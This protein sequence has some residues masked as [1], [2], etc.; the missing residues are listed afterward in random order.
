MIVQCLYCNKEFEKSLCDIKK[1]PNHYCSRSCAAKNN[2]IIYPKRKK[3]NKLCTNCKKNIT[4]RG[5]KYCSIKCQQDYGFKNKITNWQCGLDD[6]YETNGTVRRYIKR[7]L[8]HKHNYRCSE[9]GWDKINKNTNKCPLEI[10]H[11]DGNYKNN[12]ENNLKVL[13]PNCH[14]L[15]DTYKNMNKGNGRECRK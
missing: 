7:H 10:H 3:N 9:C 6:G 12:S 4:G 1:S 14:S 5:K 8:L 2:N 13:C 15:T 11:I